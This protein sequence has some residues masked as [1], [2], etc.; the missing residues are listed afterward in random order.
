MTQV[1]ETLAK[2]LKREFKIKIAQQDV[3]KQLNSR[4][5]EWGKTARLP[6]FRP[7]KIPLPVLKK[8]FGADARSELLD[9]TVS[10]ASQKAL[11]DRNLRPA[12][13]PQI[14]LISFG[15]D[16]D[17]EFKLA[18]EV[19][20][21]I[22]PGDFSKISLER[23]VADVTDQTIDE[24]VNRIAKS[25]RQPEKVEENRAAK[26][27]DTLVIDF[28]GTVD[29]KPR[30]GMKGEN[31]TL[32]LGTK[33]FIDT[34]EDQLVGSRAGDK[35]TIKVTFPEEYHAPDLSGK[36]AEFA[37][38]VKELRAHKPVELNDELAKEFGLKDL[39]ELRQRVTDD[40]GAN[41][42][43]ISRAVIKRKL[44]DKLAETHDFELPP[45]MVE[46][47]FG[48]VWKQFE[49]AR[50]NG[51]LPADEAKKSDEQLKKDYR[52]IAERRLRLGLLLA[53]V[54]RRNKMEVSSAELRNAMIA[55]ARRF[56]GQEKA[57]VDYYTQTKGALERLRAPLLEEKVVDH[58]IAQAKVTERKVPAD[59]LTKMPG[60]ME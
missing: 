17:L 28:D 49:E 37:V 34:F 42:K 5:E 6:G 8:R 24:A 16:K 47:E 29:G 36:K 25:I 31:H 35:K 57:V 46:N 33:S 32:E 18:V 40:I 22:T 26:I 12:S 44:L 56:P 7:G 19:L 30:D 59:E 10:Q 20:P 60:E 43:Q 41:Y 3:E 58:I 52:K 51:Q 54:A 39:A 21:E 14:E 55:E 27:G 50:K 45:G 11:T 13:E 48:N 53:E 38:E 23:P 4:L 1:E 2:G 15:E 9:Q